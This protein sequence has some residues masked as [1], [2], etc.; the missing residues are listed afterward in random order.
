MKSVVSKNDNPFFNFKLLVSD[1]FLDENVQR[2]NEYAR[3]VIDSNRP[4]RRKSLLT[5]WKEVTSLEIKKLFGLVF[6]M[7][8]LGMPSYS[9]CW[10]MSHLYKNDMFSSVIS[11]E[12]FQ[13]I[14][15]FLH[16]GN[17]PQQPR[18]H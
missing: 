4:L 15:R 3:G 17:E 18:D 2:S 10:S 16:F 9:G 8:L 1:K 6:H 5:K 14:I 12:R 13:S 7:G 11:Q